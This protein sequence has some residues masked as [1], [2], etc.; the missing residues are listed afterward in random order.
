MAACVSGVA[1]LSTAK[2]S[3]AQ[4]NMN[5]LSEVAES[6]QKD[7]SSSKYYQQ[8][9]YK[10]GT[11]LNSSYTDAYLQSCIES[12]YFY[13]T[14]I[15]KLPWLVSSEEMISGYLSA[16]AVSQIA[17]ATSTQGRYTI[18]TP[19]VYSNFLDCLASKDSS[20]KE[21]SNERSLTA[22]YEGSITDT[23]KFDLFQ[24]SSSGI[25]KYVGYL[26]PS[27]YV[28]YNNDPSAKKMMAAFIEW[29]IKLE[30]PQRKELMSFLNNEQTKN[31]NSLG[32]MRGEARKAWN[33]YTAIRERMA[34]EEKERRRRELLGE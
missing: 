29:F 25:N 21:C 6:C 30:K 5:F 22:L 1:I 18:W 8:I 9:G 20:S 3:M 12:R 28:A 14:V 33:E 31:N 15:S 26:C 13:L 11:T 34:E 19:I 7:V 32:E 17:K 10:E 23:R 16:V 24:G 2:S 27:C 4:V